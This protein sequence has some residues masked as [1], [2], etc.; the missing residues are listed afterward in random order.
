MTVTEGKLVAHQT[1][2]QRSRTR[3]R[4][5]AETAVAQAG[6][7]GHVLAPGTVP[8]RVFRTDLVDP[9]LAFVVYGVPAPQ[10]SKAFKGFQ[11]GKPVLKESSDALAPW[12]RAVRLMSQQAIRDWSRRHETPWEALDE[13]VMV[14]A[15]VT[16]PETA[17]ATKRG[18]VY[19]GGTPDL[20]KLERGI[21]DAIAPSPVAASATA[22]MSE[23]MKKQA[24]EKLLAQRRSLAV[25]HDDSRIV[26]WDHTL[27][28]YPSATPEALSYSGVTIQVWRMADLDAQHSAGPIHANPD[29][30]TVALVGEL[31]GWLQP[32]TG[33]TWPEIT[34]RLLADPT[35]APSGPLVVRGRTVDTGGAR[36][37]LAAL[38]AHGPDHPLPVKVVA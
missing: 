23:A 28:V 17:A 19:A 1:K 34:E 27:K 37:L 14:S 33:E 2:D 12:R 13:P 18:D 35:P 26:C 20:D 32:A 5:K 31:R 6:A 10:G 3:A 11:G 36:I 38:L 9:V 16:V 15:V 22:G 21:G 8:R 4:V 7:A 30:G 29:G 25:V 24:R